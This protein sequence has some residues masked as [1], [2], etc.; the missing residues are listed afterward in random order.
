MQLTSYVSSM[1][2]RFPAYE[3][4]KEAFEKILPFLSR[5]GTR[6]ECDAITKAFAR[7]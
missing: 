7:V 5:G 6:T 3:L 4:N 2:R 1:G